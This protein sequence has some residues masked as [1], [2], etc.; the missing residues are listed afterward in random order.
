MVT[1]VAAASLLAKGAVAAGAVSASTAVATIGAST[2]TVGNIASGL[3]IASTAL[4]GFQ[5][6]QQQG[7]AADAARLASEQRAREMR[8]SASRERTQSAIEEAERERRLR[9]ALASQRARFAGAGIDY[10]TGSPV[11]IQDQ[12]AGQINREQRIADLRSDLQVSSL[13]RSAS[14]EL[15]AGSS[16]A[17]TL[18]SDGRTSLLGTVGTVA[19]QGGQLLDTIRGQ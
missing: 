19:Q 8:L 5:S 7:A 13:N 17:S 15:R 18:R 11:L 6:F 4:S 1:A 14:A 12:T 9:R 3:S 2:L 10:T 16:Q